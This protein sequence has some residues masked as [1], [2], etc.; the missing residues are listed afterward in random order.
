MLPP[1]PCCTATHRPTDAVRQK[2]VA[3]P[4]ANPAG[5]ITNGAPGVVGS[6]ASYFVASAVSEMPE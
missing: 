1:G 5:L 6:D 3:E 2:S 4:P